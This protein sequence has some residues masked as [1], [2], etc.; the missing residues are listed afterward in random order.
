MLP[1]LCHMPIPELWNT[2]H[3]EQTCLYHAPPRHLEVNKSH[4]CL[5]LRLE[6]SFFQTIKGKPGHVI[7]KLVTGR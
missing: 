7:R 5:G 4:P 2:E 6:E 3:V 1:A